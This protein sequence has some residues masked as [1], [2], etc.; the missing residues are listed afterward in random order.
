M[1]PTSVAMDELRKRLSGGVRLAGPVLVQAGIISSYQNW[2]GRP[3]DSLWRLATFLG[4]ET[5]WIDNARKWI[6]N[7]ERHN[8]LKAVAMVFTV[9]LFMSLA[10]WAGQWLGEGRARERMVTRTNGKPDEL[11]RMMELEQRYIRSRT[12]GTGSSLWFGISA[13]QELRALSAQSVVLMLCGFVTFSL[14][15]HCVDRVETSQKPGVV[16]SF[17]M[18]LQSCGLNALACVGVLIAP[19]LRLIGLVTQDAGAA[20]RTG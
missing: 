17:V 5:T 9:A 10:H 19:E 6:D 20:N 13:L 7:P 1:E 12:S 8:G 3:T 14:V 2:G 11:H 15:V 18:T 16:E 4:I